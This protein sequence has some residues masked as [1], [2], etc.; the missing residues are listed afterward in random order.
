[1]H[2]QCTL[3][4]VVNCCPS[5]TIT[6]WK[7]LSPSLEVTPSRRGLFL[8][9]NEN[10]RGI[11]GNKETLR[12]I[13]GNKGKITEGVPFANNENP[14]IIVT[15]KNPR[16]QKKRHLFC[17]DICVREFACAWKMG[18][19]GDSA[20]DR[21]LRYLQTHGEIPNSQDFALSQNLEHGE[22]LNVIKSLHGFNL[23]DAKVCLS[24]VV[25]CIVLLRC[26]NNNGTSHDHTKKHQRH[27]TTLE[28]SDWRMYIADML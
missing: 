4:T 2:F 8:R 14:K 10:I 21:V 26:R 18:S 23:I 6:L 28:A 3:I 7:P 27:E 25:E 11:F 1:M 9:E 13:L 12:G 5:I 24:V 16:K 20:E 15:K 22:L 17:S 19:Y